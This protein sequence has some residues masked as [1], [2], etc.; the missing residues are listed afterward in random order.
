MISGWNIEVS[1]TKDT[2]DTVLVAVGRK[3]ETHTLNLEAVGVEYDK[4]N[5]GKISVVN[6]TTNVPH[7]YALG[8]VIKGHWGNNVVY[9]GI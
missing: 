4:E 2:Y 6:E 8:D 5:D 7:I 3:A 9:F 1:F